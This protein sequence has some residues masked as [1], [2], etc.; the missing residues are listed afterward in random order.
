MYVSNVQESKVGVRIEIVV[1]P[2]TTNSLGE[3]GGKDM[4]RVQIAV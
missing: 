2:T 1:L 3:K 4:Q